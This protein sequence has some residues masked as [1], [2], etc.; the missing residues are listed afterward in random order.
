V[1]RGGSKSKFHLPQRKAVEAL[2]AGCP[3]G[4]GVNASRMLI[5]F[6]GHNKCPAKYLIVLGIPLVSL[7]ITVV[8]SVSCWED[9]YSS[10][11]SMGDFS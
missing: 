2:L 4:W 6:S 1:T 11:T 8:G 9:F 7:R 3:W 10:H 5:F